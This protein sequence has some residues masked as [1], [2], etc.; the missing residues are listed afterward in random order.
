[1]HRKACNRLNCIAKSIAFDNVTKEPAAIKQKTIEVINAIIEAYVKDTSQFVK[2]E[3]FIGQQCLQVAATWIK[4]GNASQSQGQ[5]EDQMRE[6]QQ[7]IR[8]A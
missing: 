2:L 6:H 4:P 1:M 3:K 5:V 7:L 8:Q